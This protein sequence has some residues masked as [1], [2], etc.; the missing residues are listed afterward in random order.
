MEA[1]VPTV[2]PFAQKEVKESNIKDLKKKIMSK[3]L[4]SKKINITKGFFLHKKKK[5]IKEN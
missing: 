5:T 2:S 4:Q 1:D 3:H